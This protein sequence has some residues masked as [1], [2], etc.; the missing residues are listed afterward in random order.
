MYFAHDSRSSNSAAS[1]I[2]AMNFYPYFSR[3]LSLTIALCGLVILSPLFLFLALLI[4][5]SGPGRIFYRGDR[6]GKNEQIIT[7]YKFRTM[8]AGA[9]QQ[10]GARLLT[11]K[12]NFVTPVG[13]VLR[14]LKLDE[15]PQL[16]N[17]IKGDM[18][19]IGPR[20]VRPIFLPTLKATIPR[21]EERFRVLPGITGLAQ[22]RG[23]YYTTPH[24]KLRYDL[25][26]IK[27]QSLWLDI[28][29]LCGTIITLGK[30]GVRGLQ[31]APLHEGY[32][33]PSL[34][35]TSRRYKPHIASSRS[36]YSN[37]AETWNEGEVA[38][39]KQPVITKIK[40]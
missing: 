37:Y 2:I 14:Y 3:F 15:L 6:V 31:G 19:L 40:S 7:I 11:E 9:E 23:G 10:I 34:P 24:N 16:F 12:D 39:A 26:Y 25:L 21:Y 33:Y 17:V 1:L 20:P 38:L 22:Y 27:R 8:H 29:L 35:Q 5:A 13:K 32:L 28:K 36:D 4:R 18:A 30:R